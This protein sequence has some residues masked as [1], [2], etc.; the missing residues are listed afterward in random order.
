[1]NVWDA[2]HALDATAARRPAGRAVPRP[3]AG[4]RCSRSGIGFD[5]TVYLVDGIWVFRFPRREV[6]VPLM[7]REL[8]VLPGLAP[9]LP[10][11]VPVP[12]LVGHA[13]R[14]LPLAVLGSPAG[15]RRR[16]GRRQGCP[17]TAG[18]ALA[19]QVGGFL[20][21]LHDPAVARDLGGTL[22]H[23]P[24]RRGTPSTRGP[25]AREALDRLAG[26]GTWDA[27]SDLDRQI[28]RGHRGRRPA[29]GAGRRA[30]AGRT[31]TCT[32]GT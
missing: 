5:N 11:P 4:R 3:G 8:A 31:A 28:D 2:E 22:P 14:R 32:C 29:A 23:D 9:R 13:R 1:M 16:A 7:E 10:L 17:T 25:M 20:R 27:D 30:G 12:E 24:M 15:A 19:A 6:A 26:R 21:A 18:S